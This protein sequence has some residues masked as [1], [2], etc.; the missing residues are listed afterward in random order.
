MPAPREEYEA[1]LRAQW[2]RLA[3][4]GTW[5][6]GPERM[7]IAAEARLATNSLPPT[8]ALPPA[9]TDAARTVATEASTIRPE[10]IARWDA[11]GLDEYAYVEIVGIVAIVTALDV[12]AF[13]L[14]RREEPLPAGRPGE[15]SRVKP[16]GAEKS[17]G[18]VPTV[19]PA[20]APEA[21]S[22]VPPER[23]A[24]HAVHGPL[25]LTMEQMLDLEIERDGMSRY[26]IELVAAR[27]SML[28]DC[29]Y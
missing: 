24:M 25:Y 5:W 4:P 22:A 29:F 20:W 11:A 28:N 26:Q 1:A 16:D 10:M 17:D 9:A 6:T 27:T 18:W 14:G 21:L 23:D 19:G 3:E 7:A 8:G 13:G 12:A 2:Q 15:P